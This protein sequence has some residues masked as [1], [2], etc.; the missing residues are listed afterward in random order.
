MKVVLSFPLASLV[1]S[2]YLLL[3]SAI[4]KSLMNWLKVVVLT[5]CYPKLA[6]L[7]EE[8]YLCGVSGSSV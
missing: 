8:H 2:R 5:Q 6:K 1:K 4:L 7:L 3:N